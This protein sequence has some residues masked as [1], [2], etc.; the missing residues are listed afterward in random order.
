MKKLFFKSVGKGLGSTNPLLWAG[1]DVGTSKVSCCI[2]R[3][4]GSGVRVIGLGQNVAKGL[5]G[6]AIVDMGALEEAIRGAVSRAEDM[7]KET[8]AGV[9]VSVSASLVRGDRRLVDT[10]IVGH[11][12]DDVDLRKVLMHACQS[13][14]H[15]GYD[16]L[17]ALPTGYRID[18]TP[19]I[20]DPR[21][22][23]GDV[24][25]ADIHVLSGLRGALRNL[26]ACIERCHLEVKGFVLGAYAAGLSVLV[27]DE[28]DLG[29]TLVDMGAGTTTAASFYEGA[30]CQVVSIP[31]GGAHV[32]SDI[33]RGLSTPL[34]QAERIKTLYGSAMASTSHELISAPQIG[35]EEGNKGTQVAK[36][37][38]LR[39]VRP[40][41]E[42]TFELLRDQL[43]SSQGGAY[44]HNRL[45]LTGGASQLAGV[46]ELAEVILGKS[47]RLGKPAYLLGYEDRV[48]QAA[49]S[50]CAGLVLYAHAQEVEFVPVNS[51]AVPKKMRSW[52]GRFGAWFRENV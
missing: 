28:K 38:L 13:L 12:V 7:A 47:A 42:E 37:E 10:S 23:F 29:V 21:G 52:L 41:M 50:T 40:R 34:V 51:N 3:L 31:L 17:H 27:D 9:Y 32:T 22:M 14:D 49:F 45:V 11:A 16:I 46:R 39:I 8:I 43:K 2:A 18:E 44:L 33:A 6:G 19:G 1:L 26:A 4:D 48:R 35:E 30:L 20:R 25:K 36:A 24:L 5:K 15:P